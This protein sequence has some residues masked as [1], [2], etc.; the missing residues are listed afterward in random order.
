MAV[1][2]AVYEISSVRE[3]RDLENWVRGGTRSLKMALFDRPC[4]MYDFLLVCHC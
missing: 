3:R 4:T 1:S 2:L